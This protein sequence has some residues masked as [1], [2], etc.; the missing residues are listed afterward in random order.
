MEP[1][2]AAS[3]SKCLWVI[4]SNSYYMSIIHM[5]ATFMTFT[6]QRFQLLPSLRHL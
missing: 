2:K 5:L 3:S 6:T 1:G 4:S